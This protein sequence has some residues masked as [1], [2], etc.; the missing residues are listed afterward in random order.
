MK[1]STGSTGGLSSQQINT[2]ASGKCHL[3]WIRGQQ[4]D[5]LSLTCVIR[6]NCE[7][8]GSES[9]PICCFCYPNQRTSTSHYTEVRK[10]IV[11]SSCECTILNQL[12]HNFSRLTQM[13]CLR[14]GVSCRNC[15]RTPSVL[16]IFL[17][18]FLLGLLQS[19]S[20]RL[21]YPY[22]RCDTNDASSGFLF[23]VFL[24]IIT[25]IA[26]QKSF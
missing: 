11:T 24:N 5:T 7:Q 20:E 15:E 9:Q 4:E 21:M 14:R 1:Y 17:A 23:I 12:S 13:E 16:L 10:S 19:A 22:M 18:L 3:S 8:P 6:R 26:Y 2:K 25:S